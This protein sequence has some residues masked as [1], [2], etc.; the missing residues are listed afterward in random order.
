MN[1]PPFGRTMAYVAVG[2]AIATVVACL[3]LLLFA[4]L[5]MPYVVDR[6][7]DALIRTSERRMSEGMRQLQR[8]MQQRGLPF[9]GR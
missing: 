8:Q 3:V 7:A 5:A 6:Y 9:G 4:E 2:A 1:L